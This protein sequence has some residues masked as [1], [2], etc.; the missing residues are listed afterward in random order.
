MRANE[1]QQAL[2]SCTIKNNDVQNEIKN[3]IEI[4]MYINDNKRK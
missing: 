1:T 2:K 3:I 4:G